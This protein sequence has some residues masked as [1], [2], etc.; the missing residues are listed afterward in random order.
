MTNHFNDISYYRNLD[1]LILYGD[2]WL[3]GAALPTN[4]IGVP[5]RV[6]VLHERNYNIISWE[7]P[8]SA[9]M[10]GYYVYRS[11][12]I[13][14]A[15]AKLVA[16]IFDK[17]ENGR[18]QTCY[19]DY[20]LDD[21]IDTQFYYSVSS[22]NSSNFFSL[23]SDWAADMLIDNSFTQTKYLYTDQLTQTYWSIIDLYKQL[24]NIDTDRNIVPFRDKGSIYTQEM[25]SADY[26][27]LYLE[28]QL[29]IEQG[30]L[31][32][33]NNVQ[34]GYIYLDG[35]ETPLEPKNVQ[36]KVDCN[37]LYVTPVN[38]PTS[39]KYTLYMD[40]VKISSNVSGKSIT[41]EIFEND[42]IGNLTN[43]SVDKVTFSSQVSGTGIYDFYWNSLN[44]YWQYGDEEVNLEEFGISYEGT[45]EEHNVISVDFSLVGFV[46]FRVPYIYNSKV[47]QTYVV[48]E[49]SDVKFNEISFKTYNHLI[50]AST[51]GKIFNKIQIDLR[52]SKG[53][54]YVTDVSDP[55]VY[56]NFA[57][58]FDFPQPAWM[59]NINYRN[60]V[61]GNQ[62]D[63]ISGF[64]QAGMHGGTQL[65]MKQ[66]VSALS[67][68]NASFSS[69]TDIDYLTA[70][71]K[72]YDLEGDGLNLPVINLY[73]DDTVSYN[74]DDI[75]LY[76]DNFYM[77]NESGT[78]S[79]NDFSTASITLLSITTEPSGEFK[80]G[81]KYY[82][83]TD[84]KIY[85]A[86]E[87]NTWNNAEVSDPETG[88]Y[89]SYLSDIYIWDSNNSNLSESS[90]NVTCVNNVYKDV[91]FR[92]S[93]NETDSLSV[94]V[95]TDT[96][97]SIYNV[98]DLVNIDDNYYEVI[99]Q[100]EG[101]YN[102]I[103]VSESV[104]DTH[105]VANDSYYFNTYENK[106][107]KLENGS[108]ELSM[109]DLTADA[110]YLDQSTGK[111]YQYDADPYITVNTLI[112]Q[113]CL[114]NVDNICNMLK[115]GVIPLNLNA[116]YKLMGT[117][118]YLMYLEE[119]IEEKDYIFLDEYI[120]DEV[121]D[122][123]SYRHQ[124]IMNTYQVVFDIWNKQ[125]TDEKYLVYGNKIKLNNQNILYSPASFHVYADENMTQ[126][127]SNV[128]YTIDEK[129]GY[130]IWNYDTD[131]PENGSYIWINYTV[132]IR[133]DIKKLI[134]LIKFPQV[135]IKYVW[136]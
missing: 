128:L 12:T 29:A 51:F 133:P 6:Y 45:P 99:K 11:K 110:V 39:K 112:P 75:V 117:Q 17:D 31:N 91:L 109:G 118:Y 60:C 3:Y 105:G 1:P 26:P 76:N 111:I 50:F 74:A 46:Y 28:G 78:V 116:I 27:S 134:E 15:D 80:A 65:G 89:Y 136:K 127:I 38:D 69:L 73:Q 115:F 2:T 63:N 34:Q 101:Y 70:Y 7:N 100:I 114:R 132:D 54:L 96:T 130:L 52:E 53:N 30:H 135:N 62:E 35:V 85:T 79:I 66:V 97:N 9:D 94:N 19:I 14:H 25:V 120:T 22:M 20:L 121:T 24:G 16:M 129:N 102:L 124:Y 23:H 125:V 81:S 33:N 58:Y 82:N 103:T 88:I 68:G 106:L 95:I 48:A 87:E 92:K 47:L 49:D 18:T 71:N 90:F 77:V 113:T 43:L 126:L 93:Y 67:E 32:P 83:S 37:Y 98:N 72:Y 21:E 13:G 108:W 119:P 86:T 59:G 8:S 64:W 57:S 56:K 84:K 123:I 107:Y 131:K 42:D 36:V 4:N 104:P 40:N 41:A 44:N 61:L 55:Y 10:K 5:Q 122:P